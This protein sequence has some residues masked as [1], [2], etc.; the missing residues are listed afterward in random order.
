M[1]M[2]LDW[3]PENMAKVAMKE[4]GSIISSYIDVPTVSLR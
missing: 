2:D 1:T 3:S 4:D